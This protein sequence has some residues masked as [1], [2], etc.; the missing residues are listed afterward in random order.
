MYS[1]LPTAGILHLYLDL[2]AAVIFQLFLDLPT[3]GSFQLYL[4]LTAAVFFYLYQIC[5]QQQSFSSCFGSV[6]SWHFP[7]V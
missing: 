1:D 7:I 6:D 2:T 4:N 5:Q 3:A